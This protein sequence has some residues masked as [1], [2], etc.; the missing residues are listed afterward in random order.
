MATFLTA[1]SAA[2]DAPAKSPAVFNTKLDNGLELIVIPDRRTPVVTHMIWY[3]V[4]SADEP[5]GKSGIAHFLEH[6]MFKGTTKHPSGAF[7]KHIAGIG[8]QENAFTSHD[9]TG[10]FQRVAREHLG[11]LMDFE[12]DR[13]TGL[14]LTDPV[15][16]PERDVVLEEQSSRIASDPSAVLGEEMQAALFRNHPYSHPVIGWRPEIEKLNREDALAFYRKFYTPSNAVV[17]VSGDV[18]FDEVNALAK[19]T[20]GT[21]KA[22]SEIEARRRPHEPEPRAA[23]QVTYADRRVEQPHMQRMYLVPSIANAASGEAEALSVMAHLLGGGSNSLLYR[24]LVVE[25]G[26]ATNVGAW[27]QSAALDQARLGLYAYPRPGVSLQ[28]IE[29]AIDEV[30]GDLVEKELSA[31]DIERT[32]TRLIA[33]YVYAADSQ[34]TLARLYGAAL[35]TGSNADEVRTRPDRLRAVNAAEVRDAAKRWLDKKRSVTGYLIKAAGAAEEKK[36]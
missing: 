14:V 25:K 32:K 34:T 17:V 3:K 11:A 29:R 31:T 15:V 16:L 8:G 19:K 23:R 24:T 9:Y 27:Y 6:L 18:S 28:Q 1:A 30:I 21:I 4:G 22:N 7:S 12:S 10:Y 26:L 35:T 5:P 2:P 13:M 33:D 36:S 20:Y